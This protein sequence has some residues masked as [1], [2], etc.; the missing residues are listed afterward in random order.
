MH[1]LK[2]YKYA[3]TKLNYVSPLLVLSLWVYTEVEKI[4]LGFM[5][6]GKDRIK[7][8]IMYQN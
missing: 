8:R 2:N 5:W 1:S 3:L 7:T 4:S 6:T